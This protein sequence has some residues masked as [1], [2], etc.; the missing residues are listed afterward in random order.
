MISVLAFS[1]ASHWR[2]LLV[3]AC[4]AR[5]SIQQLQRAGPGF[6]KL[7][8][9]KGKSNLIR[10]GHRHIICTDST[11]SCRRL[12]SSHHPVTQPLSRSVSVHGAGEEILG[13]SNPRVAAGEPNHNLS[14]HIRGNSHAYACLAI[15][16]RPGWKM[17][18]SLDSR[19]GE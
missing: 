8:T 5:P 7:E 17:E 16:I 2:T 3:A 4:G 18:G 15:F 1:V 13:K 6:L 11:K 12:R 9:S 19:T 14:T 10:G